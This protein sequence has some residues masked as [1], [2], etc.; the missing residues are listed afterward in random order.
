[1]KCELISEKADEWFS[2]YT[3]GPNF[4]DFAAARTCRP[5]NAS[6]RSSSFPCR[7]RIGRAIRKR[8]NSSASTAPRSSLRSTR[9]LSPSPRRS[10]EARHRK[11]GRE[12]D[13]SRF[14]NSPGLTRLLP[15]QGRTRSQAAQ[16]PGCAINTSRG[17][18]IVS[19]PHIGREQLWHT[20]GH[21]ENYADGMFVGMELDDASR[22]C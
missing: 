18:S 5:P 8:R 13:R 6:R 16:E 1:M 3:L 19:T 9:R 10:K 11:L 20:S 2:E 15:S 14:R 22:T 7:A 4:I 12:L 21:L 17:Y